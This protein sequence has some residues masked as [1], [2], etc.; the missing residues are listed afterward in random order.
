M[1]T[2]AAFLLSDDASYVT[3]ETIQADGAR[4][5]LNG[6]VPIPWGTL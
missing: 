4:A 2:I 5:H 1:A 3:G 6:A